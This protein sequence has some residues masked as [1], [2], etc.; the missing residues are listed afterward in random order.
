MRMILQTREFEY[1]PNITEEQKKIIHWWQTSRNRVVKIITANY[2]ILIFLYFL[3]ALLTKDKVL[4]FK[5]TF[6]PN[7]IYFPW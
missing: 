4:P 3:A 7:T 5:L 1:I 6:K 2:I